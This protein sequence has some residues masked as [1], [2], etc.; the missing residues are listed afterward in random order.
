[1]GQGR[2]TSVARRLAW[3][4]AGVAQRQVAP[5]GVVRYFGNAY[6]VW[7]TRVACDWAQ[8]KAAFLTHALGTKY[9]KLAN[10]GA[11]KCRKL[12]P[13]KD[14]VSLNPGRARGEC[15]GTKPN[16]TARFAWQPTVPRR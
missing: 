2:L 14:I 13:S 9:M 11:F 15:P 1:M 10:L 7:R 16:S 8:T 5:S 4:V 6:W 3:S 12:P